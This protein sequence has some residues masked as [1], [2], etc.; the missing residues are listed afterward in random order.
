MKTIYPPKPFKDFETWRK[1]IKKQ[2]NK[3]L[4][5]EAKFEAEFMR[6]WSEFKQSIIKAR[7]K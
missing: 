4:S 2:A 6:I 1:W 7:T 5:P 3:N